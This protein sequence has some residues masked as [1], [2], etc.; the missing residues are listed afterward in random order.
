MK[1]DA[2]QHY[3]KVE[4][5]DYGWLTP[6]TGLLYADYMPEQ[7]EE[8]LAAYGFQR[9]IVV[10]AAPTVEETEFM[11]DLYD[12]HESIIG[13]VGWL[14]LDAPAE[15]FAE[16][17]ARLRRH[18][19][20]VGFRPMLQDLPDPWILRPRVMRNLER[21]VRDG[22]PLDLQ[23]RPRHL[24]YMLE[25]METYP[26]LT[27]VIDHAAKPFI[28][29]GV[30]D[31]WREQMAEIAEYPN[32]MCKLS[33]LVTEADQT[34]W[35]WKELAPYVRHVVSVFGP[36]RI[37]YGS[38]WPVCLTTCSY[39]DVHDALVKALP[40][41]LPPEAH[42]DLFGGNAIRFYKPNRLKSYLS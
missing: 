18:E 25:V 15:Q 5:G 37:M 33:G 26:T 21:I 31:P 1:V 16:T 24:P 3:W 17:F 27:A 20:F 32:V 41:E 11:L 28:A 14:E 38:D 34:A 42:A 8:T 39:E 22:F 10:Q 35:R 9:T 23:L 4:R 12:Q 30:L 40:P 2:H 19:G 13:V 29:E 36:D 7:L 6:S